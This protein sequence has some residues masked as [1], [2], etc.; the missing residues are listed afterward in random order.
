M[1]LVEASKER[2]RIVF[3]TLFT[4]EIECETSFSISTAYIIFIFLVFKKFECH[5]FESSNKHF[6]RSM[7]DFD[8]LALLSAYKSH[9][10]R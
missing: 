8:P 3:F 9:H 10:D 1:S 7:N 4:Q 5:N 6:I 2:L